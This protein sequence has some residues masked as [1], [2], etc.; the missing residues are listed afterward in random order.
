MIISKY[1]YII[2]IT[3]YLI[4]LPMTKCADNAVLDVESP[5]IR[6]LWTYM[7]PETL[8][9]VSFATEKLTSRGM[10]IMEIHIHI[11]NL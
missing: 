7:I 2:Y 10:P 8:R 4:E 1:S 9:N 6:R 3:P 5:Q 11:Y